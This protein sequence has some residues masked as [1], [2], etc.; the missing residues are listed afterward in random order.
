SSRWRMFD[1]EEHVVPHRGTPSSSP[2]NEAFGT[3]I[4][5]AP[6]VSMYNILQM[7]VPAEDAYMGKT[8]FQ[9]KESYHYSR[10]RV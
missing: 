8:Q 6:V 4:R 10:N 2:R 7:S 5:F 1:T 9:K 3:E